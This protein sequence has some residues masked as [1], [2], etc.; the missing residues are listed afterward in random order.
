MNRQL[1]LFLAT[2]ISQTIFCTSLWAFQERISLSRRTVDSLVT[3]GMRLYTE[4]KYEHAISALSSAD[5]D[6]VS[7]QT[8]F[9][10]GMSYAAVNDYQ[11]AHIILRRAVHADSLNPLYRFQ[12]AKFLTQFGSTEEAQQ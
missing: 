3:V 4:G 8:L 9:Y 7:A 5:T 1:T 10:L 11:S 6:S 2:T 12:F